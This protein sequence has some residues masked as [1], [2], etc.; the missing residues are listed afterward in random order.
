MENPIYKS[1][2]KTPENNV[3][4][5]DSYIYDRYKSK[6]E[7]S[8]NQIETIREKEPLDNIQ[9]KS[10]SH[11]REGENKEKNKSINNSNSNQLIKKHKKIN[12]NKN[13]SKSNNNFLKNKNIANQKET[14]L[15]QQNSQIKRNNINKKLQKTSPNE[16]ISKNYFHITKIR[17]NKNI[18]GKN[19]LSKY[20]YKPKTDIER[21][22]KNHYKTEEGNNSESSKLYISTNSNALYEVVETKISEL[23]YPIKEKNN[24]TLNSVLKIIPKNKKQN[25]NKTEEKRPTNNKKI[26][27]KEE[28][29]L[30]KYMN[31]L[32]NNNNK[33][34]V[35]SGNK[36]FLSSLSEDN[37][38]NFHNINKSH[39]LRINKPKLKENLTNIKNLKYKNNSNNEKEKLNFIQNG[40]KKIYIYNNQIKNINE[41]GKNRILSIKF[42][43]FTKEEKNHIE[44]RDFE[45]RNEIKQNINH[46]KCIVSINKKET[47]KNKNFPNP[48][49][50]NEERNKTPEKKD[51]FNRVNPSI[52]IESFKKELENKTKLS[53]IKYNIVKK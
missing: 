31:N 53:K 52:L 6:S 23:D 16:N 40:I 49:N 22:S 33:K 18:N 21:K 15:I 10:P 7:I 11:K 2:I 5:T 32:P 41:N 42:N 27:S 30:Y 47:N 25:L 44:N 48:N 39:N 43:N 36:H 35:K 24:V 50:I 19:K 20:I 12:K 4:I 13:P 3:I 14:N 37:I 34:Y 26:I 38:N 1:Y 8:D 9:R 45:K 28:L 51:I 29:Q 17:K 46:K